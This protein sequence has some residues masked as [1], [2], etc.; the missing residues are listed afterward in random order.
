MAGAV[1]DT[2]ENLAV[3]DTYKNLAANLGL[4][5]RIV[6][7]PSDTQKHALLAAA[8]VFL[9]PSDNLQG[10]LRIDLARSG[11]LRSAGGGF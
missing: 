4:E 3:V 9:S 7:N 2:P 1:E 8:D 6:K 5:M 10:N 11:R